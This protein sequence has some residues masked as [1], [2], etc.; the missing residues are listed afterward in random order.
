MIR[1]K[2]LSSASLPI[3]IASS[4]CAYILVIKYGINSGTI[5]ANSSVLWCWY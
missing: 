1:G 3:L 5:L 2:K 4:K